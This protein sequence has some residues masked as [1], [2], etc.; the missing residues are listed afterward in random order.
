[1]SQLLVGFETEACCKCGILMVIES[2]HQSQLRSTKNTFYCLNGHPQSYTQNEADRLKKEVAAK[3][4]RIGDLL[5]EIAE[6]KKPKPRK[7]RVKT[8]S[9]AKIIRLSDK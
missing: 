5:I 3:Q 8:P 1:M 9:K 2:G 7:K 6:L 4:E